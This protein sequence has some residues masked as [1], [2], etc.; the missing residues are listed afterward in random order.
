[1]R[2]LGTL[3]G[4]QSPNQVKT[5]FRKGPAMRWK[6]VAPGMLMTLA[7][8]VATVAHS[9]DIWLAPE[10]FTFAKGDILVVRQLAGTELDTQY[11]LP[12]MRDLTRRFELLTPTGT[13]DLLAELPDVR[14]Q[15]EVKP[16][17]TR[18]LDFEGLALLTME[19]DF[20]HDV[21]TTEKF[22]EYLAHEDLELGEFQD[23]I[24]R[25]PE[26]DERYARVLKSLIQ[27]GQV[28]DADLHER[29]LGLKIEIL[30]QQN[31][32]RLDPGD[33]LEVQVLFEGEPLR[34]KVVA[35]FNRDADGEVSNF[36]ARTDENGV[37]RF[38][39][40]RAGAWLVRLVHMLPC[41]ERFENDC[42][43]VDW[44]SY[45]TSFSFSLD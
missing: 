20:I 27:V 12:L 33:D 21:F 9:H 11:D 26:E 36:K 44:E 30:L 31:P 37:A 3:A 42:A 10:R 22:L 15:P 40:P 8:L 35:A 7:L 24:G 19:Q 32:Y 13:I 5:G 16:V 1:M 14:T 41:A 25:K 29:V 17:L 38:T 4:D 34:D 28:A 6:T 45:W 2:A 18:K 23:R 43:D 39:L